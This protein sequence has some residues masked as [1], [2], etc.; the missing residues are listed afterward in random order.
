M[1]KLP[2][3]TVY[4]KY[5]KRG[6]D[7]A[8][9]A[10][11]LVIL[12]PVFLAVSAAIFIEDPGPVIF[13]Q[14][15]VGINKTHFNLYKFR[16][17]KTSTPKD[18]PTHLLDNPDQ[19]ITKVGKFIRK[20]SLDELPQ[21][22]NCIKG[23][24]AICGPRPALWNQYDLIAE[25]DKYGAN[26]IRPGITGWA[27]VNGRD[28]LEIPEKAKLDGKYTRALRKNS[29]YGIITDIRVLFKTFSSVLSSDGVVEGGTGQLNNNADKKVIAVLSCH[30]PSL[31]WFRVDMMKSFIEEGYE[32]YALGNEDE[33]IWKDKFAEEGITYKKIEVER[34]GVNP[35]KDIKTIFSIREVL[36]SI[37]PDK[38]FTFQAKTVIYGGIAAG[39]LK[40]K[41]VYPLIAGMGSVFL[42][43]DLKTR[44]IR[45]IMVAEYRMGMKHSDVV[46][47]QNQD[48]VDIFM[49]NHILTHQDVV[50]I[51]GSGVNLDKFTV[52]P[53]P[54]R[55]AFLYIGR[56]IKDKGVY[57]YLKAARIFKKKHPDVRM[58]LVGP[59][60]SNPT[61]LKPEELEPFIKDGI[62]EYF[63]EQED[64][65]PFLE[66]CSVYVLPTYREGTPKTNLEAMAT[67]RA[68]IT[69]DAP[70][71]RETVEDN[72]NGFLVPVR[73]VDALV[74]KMEI[75]YNDPELARKMG[76][77]GRRMA[78][79]KFDVNI[80]NGIIRKT[81]DI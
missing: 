2:P 37:K 72:V 68:V 51:P 44:L 42:K 70:G 69:T 25:R 5:I 43:D 75:L 61:S 73:D 31:F 34:N 40:I 23:D 77:E 46:F 79:E 19:Y 8:A 74:E 66:Q 80:V 7:V 63:G 47:F 49:T 56:L 18:V 67:G 1:Y 60:D 35:L 13:T 62:I 26:D 50:L 41:E 81:M 21:L 15:R 29:L 12:S 59:Y 10:A 45:K 20:T 52:K 22:I 71:S 36:S 27:Q 3:P 16:S 33:D 24:V 64:V 57:E 14:K 58:L 28:E 6:I 9:S 11:G 54:E 38:I 78:E 4:E 39:S 55:F 53:Y 65:R 30:T 17:M 76:K 32:V 48:D